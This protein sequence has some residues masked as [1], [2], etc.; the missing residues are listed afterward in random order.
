M[1]KYDKQIF[2]PKQP[3]CSRKDMQSCKPN[4]Y[5]LKKK[6]QIY[7]GPNIDQKV[8]LKASIMT[9]FKAGYS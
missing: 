6:C 4:R 5:R 2:K 1:R 9:D 3:S 7:E 8:T